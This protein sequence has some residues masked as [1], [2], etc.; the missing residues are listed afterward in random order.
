MSS[1]ALPIAHY[2]GAGLAGATITALGFSLANAYAT[3]LKRTPVRVLITGAAGNREC[4][5]LVLLG[6]VW[7][8]ECISLFEPA[9]G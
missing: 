1:T 9:F 4:S 6:Q 5:F 7:K 2:V 3:R 8:S